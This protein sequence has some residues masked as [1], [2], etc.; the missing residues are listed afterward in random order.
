MNDRQLLAGSSLKLL[1]G[2]RR[3]DQIKPEPFFFLPSA[4]GYMLMAW[5]VYLALG[6]S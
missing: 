6:T 5:D 1:V 4:P 2:C 3:L